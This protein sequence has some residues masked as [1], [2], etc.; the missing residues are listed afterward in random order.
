MEFIV[1]WDFTAAGSFAASGELLVFCEAKRLRFVRNGVFVKY[2]LC[3]VVTY[4]E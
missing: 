3:V 4:L 2:Y 1:V